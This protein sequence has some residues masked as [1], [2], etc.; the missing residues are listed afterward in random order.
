MIIEYKKE[1]FNAYKKLVKELWNDITDEDIIKI[2][3]EHL[4]GK[5]YIFLYKREDDII[6][7]INTSVRSD[8][9]PG[10]TGNGVA[11]IEGIYVC[12]AYRRNQVAIRLV[13]HAMKFF[14]NR[15]FT[16]IASDTLIEN[17][18]SQFLHKAIGFREVE[19]C[20][21]FIKKLGE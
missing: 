6:G 11:Y 20:V 1:Y 10:S 21:H 4:S 9:V 14:K 7:F 8:Y 3:N 2:T 13:E 18:V 15:G 17:E 16:E 12:K 5:E 19:R